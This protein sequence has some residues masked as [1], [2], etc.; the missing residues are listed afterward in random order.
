MTRLS[1]LLSTYHLVSEVVFFREKEN[2]YHRS[3]YPQGLWS[4]DEYEG[5]LKFIL[6][7]WTHKP[8]IKKDSPVSYLRLVDKSKEGYVQA[9]NKNQPKQD[10]YCPLT[11]IPIHGAPLPSKYGYQRID[12]TPVRK[13][14]KE[15]EVK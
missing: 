7:L 9:F 13:T 14:S 2:N 6:K 11:M 8:C 15:N 4:R 12:N 10:H 5:K 3:Y 1:T